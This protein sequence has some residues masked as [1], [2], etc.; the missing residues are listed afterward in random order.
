MRKIY[1][2]FCGLFRPKLP[3][4][5]VLAQVR[6]SWDYT[7]GQPQHLVWSAPM[8]PTRFEGAAEENPVIGDPVCEHK[9][10][11]GR[12]A[13][14]LEQ[15]PAHIRQ[16]AVYFPIP[17]AIPLR[18]VT[19]YAVGYSI[20]GD[21]ACLDVD[22]RLLTCE[23]FHYRMTQAQPLRGEFLLQELVRH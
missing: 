22:P 9:F 10:D 8:D 4:V 13:A 11:F 15:Q 5:D 1:A 21:V 2:W 7:I 6:A 17:E 18:R 20:E 12:M 14:W 3:R 16:L 19:Y 23:Q